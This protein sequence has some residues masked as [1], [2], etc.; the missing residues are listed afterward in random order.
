MSI[1]SLIGR[2]N[3]ENKKIKYYII[4]LIF[5]KKKTKE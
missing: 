3:L 4:Y 2:E 1:N 5:F